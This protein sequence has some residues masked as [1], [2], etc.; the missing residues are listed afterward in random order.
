MILY[1]HQIHPINI[2]LHKGKHVKFFIH[3]F[4]NQLHDFILFFSIFYFN[5][6]N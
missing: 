1:L 4:S 2:Y 6:M 5:E 3:N